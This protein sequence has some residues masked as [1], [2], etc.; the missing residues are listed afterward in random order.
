MDWPA[1]PFFD[2]VVEIKLRGARLRRWLKPLGGSPAKHLNRPADTER[3]RPVCSMEV[4]RPLYGSAQAWVCQAGHIAR[5]RVYSGYRCSFWSPSVVFRRHSL[6][7]Y[8]QF[9]TK[10]PSELFKDQFKF[11]S[12]R[13][14]RLSICLSDRPA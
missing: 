5:P 10:R 6:Y 8:E 11:S 13:R 14:M 1:P 12:N 7:A 9:G 3:H 4:R 2:E